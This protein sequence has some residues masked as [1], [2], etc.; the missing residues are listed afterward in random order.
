MEDNCIIINITNNQGNK[1]DTVWLWNS[2]RYDQYH[3]EVNRILRNP[4]RY[5]YDLDGKLRGGGY[6]GKDLVEVIENL[7]HTIDFKKEKDISVILKS[8]KSR[9]NF[10]E[11]ELDKEDL[12]YILKYIS[13]DFNNISIE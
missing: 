12:N 2:G 7:R 11:G 10:Y 4:L 9:E 3:E 13:K 8:K 5:T 6:C 1:K